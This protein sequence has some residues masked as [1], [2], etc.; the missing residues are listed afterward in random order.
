M[1]AAGRALF[2]RL[3]T[4][5][6]LHLSNAQTTQLSDRAVLQIPSPFRAGKVSPN[7]A[8][9]C[10]SAMTLI[11]PAKIVAQ[12]QGICLL[13]SAPPGWRHQC[14]WAR[15]LCIQAASSPSVSSLAASLRRVSVASASPAVSDQP[16]FS[17]NKF[18]AMKAA[19]LLPS[20][21]G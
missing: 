5:Y 6:S 14:R 16:F 8:Q 9:F 13:A 7:Q 3:A 1:A 12:F 21:N 17:R 20:I 2:V 15:W 10:P 4:L 11:N 18:I 19:R